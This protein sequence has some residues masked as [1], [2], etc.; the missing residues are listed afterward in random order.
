[1]INNGTSGSMGKITYFSH[2][3]GW[4]YPSEVINYFSSHD[5]GTLSGRQDASKQS[6][7][8][9]AVHLLTSLGIPMIW[10]G[11]EVAR[12]HYGNHPP[13]GEGID[14]ANNEMDWDTLRTDNA[15]LLAYYSGLIKLR[16]AHAN[17]HM[18]VDPGVNHN[19]NTDWTAGHIGYTYKQSGDNGFVVLVNYN[20]TTAKT[21]SATFPVTGTWY[22]MCDGVSA[23]NLAPGLA[24]TNIASTTNSISVPANTAYIYMSQNSL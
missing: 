16:I 20:K 5:E 17:L 23:T 2:D 7:K 15:D 4:N 11:D 18:A 19:W 24:T 12:L 10:M 8:T 13:S 1:M 21:F 3:D 6:V 22:Q 9:A 14:E